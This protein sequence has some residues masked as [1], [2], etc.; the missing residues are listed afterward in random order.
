MITHIYIYIYIY[1][2]VCVCVCICACIYICIQS[3][4]II[5]MRQSSWLYKQYQ[6]Q[7]T[8]S[9]GHFQM[10]LYCQTCSKWNQP[11]EIDHYNGKQSLA[12]WMTTF[13]RLVTSLAFILLCHQLH[14][15]DLSRDQLQPNSKLYVLQ[16]NPWKKIEY[17]QLYIYLWHTLKRVV[18]CM[19]HFK[20]FRL[21]HK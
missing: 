9:L 16:I 1:I 20:K 7:L 8:I 21:K 10:V 18:R 3:V 13:W 14:W 5:I 2:Y 12:S 15:R 11:T 19:L 17:V 4:V 6:S